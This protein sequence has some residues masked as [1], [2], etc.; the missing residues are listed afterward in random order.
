[1]NKERM[2]QKEPGGL[3]R[4]EDGADGWVRTEL[5]PRR[6]GFKSYVQL[7]GKVIVLKEHSF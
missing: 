2:L 3:S 1:M 6:P 5:S 4:L 7:I